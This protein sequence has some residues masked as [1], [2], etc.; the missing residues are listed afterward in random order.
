MSVQSL[1]NV[2]SKI[3]NTYYE[4]YQNHSNLK[5]SENFTISKEF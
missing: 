5:H 2:I 1:F 4:F 3:S